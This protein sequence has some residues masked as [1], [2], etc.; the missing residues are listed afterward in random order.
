MIGFQA[1]MHSTTVARMRFARYA[2]PSQL[3][4]PSFDCCLCRITH[5][6][7]E[8]EDVNIVQFKTTIMN[9][10]TTTPVLPKHLPSSLKC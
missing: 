9:Y 1:S 6:E 8:G 3:C 5:D 7:H 4:P 10:T 2:L